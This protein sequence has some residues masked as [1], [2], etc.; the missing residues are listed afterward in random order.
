MT[1]AVRKDSAVHVSLSFFTCQRA[2][3][4]DAVSELSRS[5]ELA[6]PTNRA[7]HCPPTVRTARPPEGERSQE[8]TP[9]R[10]RSGKQ[11]GIFRGSVWRRHRVSG[12]VDGRFIGRPPLPVNTPHEDFLT[13]WRTCRPQP[14]DAAAASQLPHS[15]HSAGGFESRTAK[16]HASRRLPRSAGIVALI[17]RRSRGHGRQVDS[18]GPRP[19]RRTRPDPRIDPVLRVRDDRA[20]PRRRCQAGRSEPVRAR[21]SAPRHRLGQRAA[22][23]AGGGDAPDVDRREV[24]L[25]W[26]GASVLTGITGGALIGASIYIALEGDDDLRRAARARRRRG[27][28]APSRRRAPRARP[29]RATSSSAPR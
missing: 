17:P 26:L 3:S 10:P 4:N 23:Q 29:A 20:P 21:A 13:G 1:R 22:A 18:H 7:E 2:A 19:D 24:N 11:P 5:K 15:R 8:K 27:A 12:G 16:L 9:S 25:R 28:A 6:S 14:P